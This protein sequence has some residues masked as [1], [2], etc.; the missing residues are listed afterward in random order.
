MNF[1]FFIIALPITLSVNIVCFLFA[2]L[3]EPSFRMID[4]ISVIKR[5]QREA[6]NLMLNRIWTDITPLFQAI[7]ASIIYYVAFF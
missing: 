3:F 6:H 4:G 5:V 1:L 2:L 7:I